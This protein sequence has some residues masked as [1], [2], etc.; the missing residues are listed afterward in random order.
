MRR[1]HQA[2]R[3]SF[4]IC[5]A[6]L[7]SPSVRTSLPSRVTRD[8]VLDA[9]ADVPPA[10]GHA[11]GAC[12]NVD[13]RLD[14]HHHARF[15]HAPLFADLVVADIVHIHAEPMTGAMHEELAI[16]AVAI[17]LGTLPLS[18]PEL[19]ESLRDRL[20]RGVVRIVPVIAGRVFS[21]AACCASSTTS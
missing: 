4:S 14:G 21:M 18:K 7:T 10:L 15:E 5:S 3:I 9:N 6:S 20:D 17:R 16:C 11:F 12:G 8:V 1:E 13:P 19:H 2:A